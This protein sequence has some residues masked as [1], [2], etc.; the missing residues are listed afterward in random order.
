MFR[1]FLAGL[2]SYLGYHIYKGYKS[3]EGSRD[4]KGKPKKE[5]MDLS[6]CDVGEAKY[7]DIPGDR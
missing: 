3:G 5:P 7:K 1:L 2:L 6:G 4:V